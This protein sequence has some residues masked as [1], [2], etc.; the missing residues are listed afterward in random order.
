MASTW[1]KLQ[2]EKEATKK[3]KEQ[4]HAELIRDR[5]IL[6]PSKPNN[7]K[8]ERKL[9]QSAMPA[10]EE[11]AD[12]TDQETS[13]DPLMTSLIFKEEK[14]EKK[15]RHEEAEKHREVQKNQSTSTII[16]DEKKSEKTVPP[17]SQSSIQN[18]LPNIKDLYHL[19][20]TAKDVDSEIEDNT[21]MFTRENLMMYFEALGCTATDGGKHKKV[22]L[23]KAIF[24]FYEGSTIA[25]MN[26][27][28][29]ALTLPRWDGSE[30]NG[31][32]PS[33]LRTQIL[34]AREKLVL[35]KLKANKITSDKITSDKITSDKITNSK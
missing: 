34:K 3:R 20:S 4:E 35:L 28:G 26:D 19:T 24:V 22:S 14:E 10:K 15:K 1:E 18:E 32:V 7:N 31:Q 29:G 33:Y 27:L 11:K 5:K 21:W 30:G 13:Y 12:L 16:L 17:T 9:Q 8:A 2:K 23:P 25:I 6:L